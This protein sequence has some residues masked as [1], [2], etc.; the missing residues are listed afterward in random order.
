MFVKLDLSYSRRRR[1][2]VASAVGGGRRFAGWA[3]AGRCCAGHGCFYWPVRRARYTAQIDALQTENFTLHQQL[4]AVPMPWPRTM[5]CS[6]LA[7]CGRVS[8]AV[9]PGAGPCP[10]VGGF[11]LACPG[12]CPGPPC[13]TQA[14]GMRASS[15]PWTA[16]PAPWRWSG[17]PG[18]CGAY[19]GLITPGTRQLTG[20]PADCG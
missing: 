11:T 6:R 1:R 17:L 19:A 7:R 12:P 16:T 13:W 18:Y 20:L 9:A 14:G 3:V 8:A 15:P 4:P 2:W 10:G 5:P